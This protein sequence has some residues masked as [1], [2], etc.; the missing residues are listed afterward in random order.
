[1]PYVTDYYMFLLSHLIIG[2]NKEY[3]QMI[4]C[5]HSD[6]ILLSLE[7]SLLM[8]SWPTWN[9]EHNFDP[10]YREAMSRCSNPVCLPEVTL[11]TTHSNAGV[12]TNSRE[13]QNFWHS[14]WKTTHL[15]WPD[16]TESHIASFWLPQIEITQNASEGFIIILFREQS[17]K[18]K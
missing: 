1:M 16:L 14:C 8:G 13:G 4:V 18:C 15:S 3:Y 6:T 12:G 10:L 2:Q 9:S 5:Y 7:V 17:H 11:A